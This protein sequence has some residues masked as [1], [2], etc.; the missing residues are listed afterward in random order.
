MTQ[1]LLGGQI[2]V[3][4]GTMGTTSTALVS[5]GSGRLKLLSIISP[6][7]L[8]RFKDVPAASDVEALKDFSYSLWLG[9]LVR[10]ETPDDVVQT[11][12][13]ALGEA[14]TDPAVKQAGEATQFIVARLE[15]LAQAQQGYA[16]S[17]AQYRDIANAVGFKPE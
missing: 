13:R 7:R 17:I 12:H 11:L 9:L 15:P 2:D 5:D 14:L 1:D 6:E 4:L 10:K 8:D 16:A 3:Y